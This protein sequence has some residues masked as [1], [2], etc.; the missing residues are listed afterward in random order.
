MDRR[1]LA[2]SPG[3]SEFVRRLAILGWGGE[4]RYWRKTLLWAIFSALPCF[5]VRRHRSMIATWTYRPCEGDHPGGSA[6]PFAA[7]RNRGPELKRARGPCFYLLEFHINKYF[8][9]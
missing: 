7:L 3:V 4:P 6:L 9:R 8:N 5:T 2:L 1:C